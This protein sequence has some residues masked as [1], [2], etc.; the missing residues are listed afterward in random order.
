MPVSVFAS[1]LL[2]AVALFCV[3][4]C[5]TYLALRLR[6]VDVPNHRSSHRVP[7][8]STGGIGIVATFFVG[9]AVVWLVSD[10]ARQ[11][12][13]HL[14]GFAA[15]ALGIAFVGFLDD[16]GRLKTFRIK[17]AAQILA[18]IALLAFDIVFTRF[19]LPVLGA[20]ELGWIGYPLTVIWL[21]AL[22]NMFNFMDGLNGL[23]GGTAV[24]A[25]GFLCAVTF[26]EGSF[27]VYV[28]CYIMAAS[29]AGF[30]VFNFPRARL[31]MGDVGSQFVGFS[32][33]AFAVLAAEIDTSRTSFLVVPLLFFNFI[34]DTVFTL[35]R[36]AAAGRNITQ[37]HRE[38]L[39]QLMNRL[40]VSHVRVS[41]FHHGV[42]AAQGVGALVLIE[43]GPDSRALV[44]LPFLLF[45][46]VYAAMV[47]GRARRKGLLDP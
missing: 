33:A 34:F 24:I 1:H 19:S 44:F 43:L 9:L 26:V 22:T 28:L 37:A 47:I 23:A 14:A 39:Y 38:H 2:F 21:V 42:C 41:L 40:G 15:A 29:S 18:A 12:G 35:I 46:G 31:F 36:R 30:L 5:V 4:V 13:F 11:S 20:I 27:F 8:P 25:A 16:L 7:T 3:S 32:F 17:L 45:Q 10:Q 6:I